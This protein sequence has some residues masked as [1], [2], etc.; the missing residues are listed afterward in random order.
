MQ[1]ILTAFNAFTAGH[2]AFKIHDKFHAVLHELDSCFGRHI[3]TGEK[4]EACLA[5]HRPY[6][7]DAVCIVAVAHESRHQMLNCM[8]T[9][10]G[11]I[12]ILQIVGLFHAYII[13]DN[14]TVFSGN[15]HAF[16]QNIVIDGKTCNSFHNKF[17][18]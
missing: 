16:I 11:D 15:I 7:D 1:K 10:R 17:N 9:G 14:V 12:I 4:I 5:S 8:R 2:F 6:I 3:I 18:S 13:S